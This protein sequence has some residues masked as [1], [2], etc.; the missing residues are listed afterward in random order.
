VIG[1]WIRRIAVLA[2]SLS[3]LSM[4]SNAIYASD[5]GDAR[6]RGAQVY[7]K[8]CALCHGQSGKGNGRAAGLQKKPP[9]NLTTSRISGDERLAI[10]Q[11]GGA[12]MN[13]SA[14]MP[15]WNEVLTAKEIADV[16]VY[17]DVLAQV[18]SS[19]ANAASTA[20]ALK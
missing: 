15:A 6:A 16:A 20:R 13:R 5:E 12:A 10:I 4:V 2:L 9:A 7:S 17:L 3:S 11:R 14:S 18:G 8:Y 1:L 19:S